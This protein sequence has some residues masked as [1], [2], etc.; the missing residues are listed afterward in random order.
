MSLSIKRVT[1]L[2][3][4]GLAA[5]NDKFAV[6]DQVQHPLRLMINSDVLRTFFHRGDQ[7]MLEAIDGLKLTPV[8]E[9]ERCPEFTHTIFSLETN[10][11]IDQQ[12]YDFD[13]S[14]NDE[15][16]DYL[17]F[18]GKDLRVVG[19]AQFGGEDQPELSFSAPVTSYKLEA[20]FVDEDDEQIT[21]VNKYAKKPV[22]KDF[23]FEVGEVTF[24]D[25]A[26]VS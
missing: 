6:A 8:V 10:E 4:F 22:V 16:K 26:N 17:G 2:V 13:L 1:S 5:L 21:A 25:G 15:G 9:T 12:A 23:S 14:I 18:E 20:E 11:G 24:E 19:K 3:A 7:R